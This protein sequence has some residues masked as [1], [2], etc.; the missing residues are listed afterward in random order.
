MA[1]KRAV[2]AKEDAKEAQANEAIRRKQKK[3]LEWTECVVTDLKELDII[4]R[5]AFT[6][7]FIS[8]SC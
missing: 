8:S 4:I 3:S 2:K 7:L 6:L 5:R 1:A